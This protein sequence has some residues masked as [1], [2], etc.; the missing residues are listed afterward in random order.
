MKQ[1]LSISIG[2]I[3][4]VLVTSIYFK[5]THTPNVEIPS[6]HKNY[7]AKAIIIEKKRVE[8]NHDLYLK[9]Y[10]KNKPNEPS[11]RTKE[12]LMKAYYFPTIIR[13]LRESMQAIVDKSPEEIINPNLEIENH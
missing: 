4:G 5:G 12:Y 13:Y 10:E 7:L 3:I 9:N 6:M 1:T 11:S 8:L 2:I